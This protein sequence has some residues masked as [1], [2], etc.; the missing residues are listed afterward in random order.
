GHRHLFVLPV[1]GG[2]P[3]QVTTG[4][5]DH[6][7]PAWTPDG[8]ALVFSANRREDRERMPRDTDLW[9]LDIETGELTRLTDR[10][11]PDGSP[12]V[13]RDGRIAWVGYDDEFQGYQTR[14]LYVMDADGGGR[15]ALAPGLDR[16]PGGPVWSHDGRGL[17][18]DYDSEGTGRLAFVTL[19]G[20]VTE[21][22]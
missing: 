12:A 14:R 15:R 13:A 5:Y 20:E 2:T 19:D 8:R 7:A 22:A 1:E 16:S 17:F 4:P 6:G 9:R 21:L 18:V 3:R 10:F 11:G